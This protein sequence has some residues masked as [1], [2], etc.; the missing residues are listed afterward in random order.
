[1][2]EGR[3]AQSEAVCLE[4]AATVVAMEAVVGEVVVAQAAVADLALVAGWGSLHPEV[5][6]A[7]RAEWMAVPMEVAAEAALAARSVGGMA[8]DRVAAVDSVEYP[9]A[10][11]AARREQSAVGC[12]VRVTAEALGLSLEVVTVVDAAVA[13]AKEMAVVAVGLAAVALAAEEKRE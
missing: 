10:E 1:M 11:A 4:V 3:T 6:A 13:V 2:A 8:E 7:G 12:Q 9:V 5:E